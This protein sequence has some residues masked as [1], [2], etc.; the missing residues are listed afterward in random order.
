MSRFPLLTAATDTPAGHATHDGRGIAKNGPSQRTPLVDV[1]GPHPRATSSPTS[2]PFVGDGVGW[3]VD[4]ERAALKR[5]HQ[6]II[7]AGG[8]R[9]PV[10]PREG[11]MGPWPW[12]QIARPDDQRVTVGVFHM[13]GELWA[14]LGPHVPRTAAG[15]L[16]LGAFCLDEGADLAPLAEAIITGLRLGRWPA[17]LKV[18]P[19]HTHLGGPSRL[20]LRRGP[21]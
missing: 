4:T 19:R 8:L 2:P 14:I 6:A 7:G 21:P 20:E 15:P 13:C 9:L 10:I 3:E 11:L 17:L 16:S 1:S 5:L 12:L 18:G